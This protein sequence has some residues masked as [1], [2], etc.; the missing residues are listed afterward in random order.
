MKR[1][2]RAGETGAGDER[3]KLCNGEGEYKE[4][5][6]NPGGCGRRWYLSYACACMLQGGLGRFHEC[7]RLAEAGH[8]AERRWF[9]LQMRIYKRR[10]N[11]YHKCTMMRH[12]KM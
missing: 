8:T 5:T 11:E 7:V 6:L 10:S 3:E 9:E 1:E 2:T 4:R 12:T